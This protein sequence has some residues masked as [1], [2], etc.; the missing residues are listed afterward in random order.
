MVKL[1][2]KLAAEQALLLKDWAGRDACSINSTVSILG[3]HEQHLFEHSRE[4]A[5][6]AC[7]MAPLAVPNASVQLLA[8]LAE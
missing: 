5:S 4:A 8:V 7:L 2:V 3:M 6:I 1:I